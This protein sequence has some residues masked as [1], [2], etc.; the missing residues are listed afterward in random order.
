MLANKSIFLILQF[1]IKFYVYCLYCLFVYEKHLNA[2]KCEIKIE[3]TIYT[4]ISSRKIY[5]KWSDAYCILH[6]A[7]N[8]TLSFSSIRLQ[9][10]WLITDVSSSTNNASIDLHF[11]HLWNFLSEEASNLRSFSFHCTRRIVDCNCITFSKPI[12]DIEKILV[13]CTVYYIICY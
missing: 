3:L 1:S 2:R 10:L 4:R 6:T 12:T 9:I 13:V 11:W 5:E 7:H 8:P